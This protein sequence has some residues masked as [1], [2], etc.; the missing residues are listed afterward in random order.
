MVVFVNGGSISL[1][2]MVFPKLTMHLSIHSTTCVDLFDHVLLFIFKP[3]LIHK[4]KHGTV[5]FYMQ[6]VS[7]MATFKVK[8]VYEIT[9]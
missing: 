2:P 3:A 8:P 4:L 7:L 1:I 9:L 5:T 6:T